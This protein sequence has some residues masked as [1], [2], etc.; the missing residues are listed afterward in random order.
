[1]ADSRAVRGIRLAA[2]FFFT[3]GLPL[4]TVSAI[5]SKGDIFGLTTASERLVA[6]SLSLLIVSWAGLSWFG[7]LPRPDTRRVVRMAVSVACAWMIFAVAVTLFGHA[8]LVISEAATAIF[9]AAVVEESVFRVFLPVALLALIERNFAVPLRT[10]LLVSV[11][12]SQV[13]FA[14]AHLLPGIGRYETGIAVEFARLFLAGIMYAFLVFS[15]GVWF[16]SAVHAA[17]NVDQLF[18]QVPH[19]VGGPLVA[20]VGIAL[21]II[22]VSR[23]GIRSFLGPSRPSAV[24]VH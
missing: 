11:L 4:V 19:A 10:A 24:Q 17:L 20:A 14:L 5:A 22:F 6:S 1:M 23:I 21:A 16:G 12:A 8:T 18:L 2:A 13:A 9:V 15:I 7:L 3:L